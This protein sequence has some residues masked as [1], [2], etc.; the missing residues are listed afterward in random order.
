LESAMFWGKNS[1][2]K[3]RDEMAPKIAR[4]LEN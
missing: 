4:G 2:S 3:D 1:E